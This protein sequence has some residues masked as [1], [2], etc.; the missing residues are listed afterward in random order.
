[1]QEGVGTDENAVIQS[2]KRL[3]HMPMWNACLRYRSRCWQCTVLMA[4]I[5]VCAW[6]PSGVCSVRKKCRS[7]GRLKN[8][9]WRVVHSM[10][11]S[12]THWAIPID[13]CCWSGSG[14]SGY[15]NRSQCKD[16]GMV[17][18]GIHFRRFC[19]CP[20]LCLKSEYLSDTVVIPAT[21]LARKIPWMGEWRYI[22]CGIGEVAR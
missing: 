1:M 16:T 22:K 13:I 5:P 15:K 6:I 18:A 3:S 10:V 19:R 11:L 14:R 9:S 7:D 4:A 12:V 8:R 17:L 21:K 20:H 2:R